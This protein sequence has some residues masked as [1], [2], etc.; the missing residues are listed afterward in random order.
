MNEMVK[1]LVKSV[2]IGVAAP[3]IAIAEMAL[4][5]KIAT[6]VV[7]HRIAKKEK[8]ICEIIE[9]YDT[10]EEELAQWS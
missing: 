8:E 2:A 5:G 1:G 6:T 7:N 3:Y 4:I 10:T 9:V